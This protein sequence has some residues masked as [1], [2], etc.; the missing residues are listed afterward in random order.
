[1]EITNNSI[2]EFLSTVDK[3]RI[4]DIETL[5]DI[6]RELTGKEP[7]M[8]GSIV[9]FGNLHYRY[10]TG[11]EGTMPAFGFANRKQALTLYISYTIED[12]PELE[13]LGK[14]KVG[15]SCLYI[16]KLSDVD[17]EVLK[18]MIIKGL[19]EIETYDFITD[20]EK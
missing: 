5:L 14:Y 17:L 16:K 7:K 6:G 2:A 20:L 10:K 9:G 19:E 8:W 11:H 1:M 18:A 13:K 15:K 12:Y 3:N 4:N